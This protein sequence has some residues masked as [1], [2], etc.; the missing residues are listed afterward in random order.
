VSNKDRMTF[1]AACKELQVSEEELEQLVAAGEIA[2]IKDGDALYF[3][4]EVIQSYKERRDEPAILLSDGEIDL[5]GEELDFGTEEPA[6]ARAGGEQSSRSKRVE[7]SDVEGFE[8]PEI[9]LEGSGST[10]E[11]TVLNIPGILD[12]DSEGTTP[13]SD[14]ETGV[15]EDEP[16]APRGARAAVGDE[17]LIDTDILDLGDDADTFELDTAEDTLIDATEEGTLLRGGGARVMQMKRKESHAPW[18]AGLA[19]TALIMLLPLS[20]L[21][22][23]IYRESMPVTPKDPKT[24]S[25]A[26]IE[27]ANFPRGFIDWIA[28]HF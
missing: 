26:W 16:V 27:S 14:A 23:V 1:E 24:K 21:T 17:T 11:E 4:P 12:E 15:L 18:T 6:A 13:L 10:G 5:L 28:D 22:S 20:I 8:L 7:I 2:S 9:S 19:V 25:F 3:K